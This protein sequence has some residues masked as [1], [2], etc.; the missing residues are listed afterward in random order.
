MERSTEH[1]FPVFVICVSPV[2]RRGIP[3]ACPIFCGLF[4]TICDP[5]SAIPCPLLP[6]VNRWCHP[7]IAQRTHISGFCDLCGHN[8]QIGR[9]IG[10][11]YFLQIFLNHSRP[12]QCITLP[13]RDKIVNRFARENVNRTNIF[14]YRDLCGHNG[15][16]LH[17]IGF[18]YFLWIFLY[19]SRPS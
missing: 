6:N 1:T 2:G 9:T 13:P 19:H 7:M 4:E 14:L 16:I 3:L 5:L 11:P 18:P 10:Y 12:S 8:G 17:T 15:Q